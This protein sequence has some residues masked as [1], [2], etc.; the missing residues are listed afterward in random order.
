MST[1]SVE[2]N[3]PGRAYS[4]HVGAGALSSVGSGARSISGTKASRAFVV[5]DTG[6]PERFVEQLIA[7]L[8]SQGFAACVARVTPSEEIKSIETYHRLLVEIAA[9]GHTRVDPVIA[10]GGGVVGDLAGFVAASYQRGVAV[11]QCPTTLLSM[12]DASV[13]GKTG[14]N[15]VV[16]DDTGNPALL[17]NLVGAF[18]QPKM[19][20]ADMD[21]LDSLDPRHRRAGLAECVKHGM[22]CQTIGDGHEGLMDWMLGRLDGIR[23]FDASTIEELVAK[24]VA[25]KASV[26]VRDEHES[27]DAK[28]GGRMLLNFGH[29]FG[30]AIETIKGLTPDAN[31]PG[32]APLLH[33]EA[34]GLG[35][36]AACHAAAEL[37]MCDRSV[38]DELVSMLE[39]IGLPV[40]VDGLP[41]S[42]EILDR[43]MRDKKTA[44]G[45]LR[46]ILPV[47]R[48]KCEIVEG[49]DPGAIQAGIDS[50]RGEPEARQ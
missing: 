19:V 31:D 25:I 12:V 7:D 29:T 24:N 22:I 16:T 40:R 32:L 26:V 37:G 5:V 21:V 43:M 20:V 36:V 11:I 28:A 34:V 14:M 33:G 9:T 30:H 8:A 6:V 35:M 4:V 41:I 27:T 46:V 48:G 3:L 49:A 45:S 15:L 18:H 13:G 10:L 50:I 47:G 17:K 2:V 23:G 42:S 38:G 39:A 1:R 44:G